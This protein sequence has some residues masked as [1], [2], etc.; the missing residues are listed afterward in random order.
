MGQMDRHNAQK[1]CPTR[2]HTFVENLD[3]H[4]ARRLCTF[5]PKLQVLHLDMMGLARRE[6]SLER[7]ISMTFFTFDQVA[8]LVIR[9]TKPSGI[10][11]PFWQCT[12]KFYFATWL[13]LITSSFLTI[14]L[15]LGLRSPC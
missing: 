9:Y 15:S 10:P 7:L 11:S 2:G 6:P 14:P 13:K 1:Y 5:A 12:S 8:P 4:A 3:R